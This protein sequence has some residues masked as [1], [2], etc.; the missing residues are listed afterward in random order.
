MFSAFL[1]A[2]SKYWVLFIKRKTT[3][4]FYRFPSVL[5]LLNKFGVNNDY[6]QTSVLNNLFLTFRFQSN[7]NPFSNLFYKNLF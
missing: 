4:V 7:G 3:I 1:I 2:E 5:D 6:S